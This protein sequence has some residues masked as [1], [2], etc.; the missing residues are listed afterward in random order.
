[1]QPDEVKIEDKIEEE[2]KEKS[3]QDIS[4]T[5]LSQKTNLSTSVIQHLLD[6][7]FDS[8]SYPQAIGAIAIIEREFDMK[9]DTLKAECKTYFHEHPADD[10]VSVVKA[11]P[12]SSIL[13]PQILII[14]LLLF[15][16]YSGWYFFSEYYNKQI[17]PQKNLEKINLEKTMVDQDDFK[18]KVL[19]TKPIKDI[20]IQPIEVKEINNSIN[21]EE[22]ITS[23]SLLDENLS[24]TTS[25][26]DK[27]STQRVSQ[28][29]PLLS[30]NQIVVEEPIEPKVKVI[31]P[32]TPRKIITLIPNEYMWF[33][34]INLKDKK[35]RAYKRSTKYKIDM[36]DNDWLFAAENVS[37]SFKD[38]GKTALYGGEGKLFY[39]LDQ[40]GIHKLTKEQFR[41]LEK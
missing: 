3:I 33:R 10:G 17:I 13:V 25:T 28:E 19:T 20:I 23:K 22:N 7:N 5:T 6:K 34:L 31:V 29:L 15:V 8:F 11:I 32:T 14:A 30:S 1:M 40:S 24:R 35:R 39:K 36:R 21:K 2:E 12:K 37:F 27:N 16:G 38:I 4:I 9:L 26:E 18:K 41:A